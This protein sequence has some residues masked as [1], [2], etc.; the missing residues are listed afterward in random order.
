MI[1][2]KEIYI[3]FLIC[4]ILI[5]VLLFFNPYWTFYKEKRVSDLYFENENSK[6]KICG[7]ILDIKNTS[8]YY[9]IQICDLNSCIKAHVNYKN[10]FAK[11]L[12]PVKLINKEICLFGSTKKVYRNSYLEIDNFIYINN[13]N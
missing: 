13:F 7:K 5:I 2:T 12:E 3:L 10:E 8:N 6:V 4:F 11:K 1:M 9:N